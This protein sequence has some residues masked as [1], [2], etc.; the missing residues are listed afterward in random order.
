MAKDR[1][2]PLKLEDTGTGSEID[3][4]P[5]ALDRNEDYVDCKGVV[6]QDTN[7]DDETTFIERDES[8]NLTFVDGVAGTYTLDQLSTGGSG[9][10]AE[11]HKILRQLIHFIDNG[12][13][14]GFATGAY[15]EITGTAF[16]T[17]IIWYDKAG[18]GKVK[19]VSKEIS[20]TGVLA[21]PIVWKVYDAAEALIAT[22]TDTVSYTGVFETSRTRAIVIE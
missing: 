9:I 8:G 19:I 18:A 11:G 21:S 5:T 16:P 13:A 3:L 14:E 10:S 22:V 4:F 12:P 7:S 17:A 6:I 2:Q 15:R 20:W 1:V